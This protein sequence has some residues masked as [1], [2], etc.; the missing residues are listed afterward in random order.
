MQFSEG[1]HL[2]AWSF[3]VYSAQ[4][5]DFN[6]S[7]STYSALAKKKKRGRKKVLHVH[8]HGDIIILNVIGFK[9]HPLIFLINWKKPKVIP[10][11]CIYIFVFFWLY[12]H[13]STFFEA[14]I[15]LAKS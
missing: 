6:I 11:A 3:S 7:G 13:S 2:K 1:I 12:S 5:V 15:S 10:I 9:S 8:H 4:Q 14:D